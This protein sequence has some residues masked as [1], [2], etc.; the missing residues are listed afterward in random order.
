[1]LALLST[2]A[3]INPIWL[4]GPYS[5]VSIS[6]GSQPDFYMGFLEG[7][8]RV[9]P[10][11]TWDLGGHTVAW[12]VLIP[13]LVPLGVIFTGAALWPWIERWATGDYGEH[14]INDRPRN[15]PTR[16]AI[17]MAAVTF[18][19]I[20][21]LEGANDL[22]AVHLNIPLYET[23]E[24]ARYAVF[25]GP[26]LAYFV[27]KRICLGLQR[28]DKEL[29]EHGLETGII[30]QRPNGEFVELHRPVSEETRAVLLAR[31]IPPMLPPPGTQDENGIPAPATKGIAGKLRATANRVVT[32]S[33]PLPETNGHGANGHDGEAGDAEGEH[34][35]VGGTESGPAIEGPHSG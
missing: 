19:G 14:H 6:A 22:V 35:A 32:E 34:A 18:Y 26:A 23:T 8:L 2:V 16:T 33:V 31:K 29:L 1:V 11:W 15:A 10:S 27:T 3:Q 21:L 13:A 12:N 5:P 28:K 4:Y 20:M 30:V 9:F 24:I 17:G 25:L 7:T